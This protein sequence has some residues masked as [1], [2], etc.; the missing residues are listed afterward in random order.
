MIGFN[1]GEIIKYILILFRC[2]GFI[3]LTPIFG[4]REIPNHARIGLACFLAMIV[5]PLIPDFDANMDVLTLA[6][7]I[8][9][10]TFVGLSMGYITL[11]MFSSLYVAGQIIDMQ[12]GFGI[13][14]VIDPQSNSQVP[15]IGNFYYI[16]TLLTF[17]TVNGHHVLI[18]AMIKSFEIVPLSNA[19]F[20]RSFLA[21][22]IQ[23]FR[24]MFAIGFKVSLPVI[25][26]I[27][28][29]DFALGIMARAVP[30][31]N[32][33]IVGLPIKIFI[34]ILG[35]IIIFPMY[36]TALDVIFNGTYDNILTLLRGMLKPP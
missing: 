17:L 35:I 30:Q 28:I 9:R 21:A 25:S 34:G 3:M 15:L 11:M 26:I 19:V 8:L 10:E 7:S 22:I 1:Y 36:L 12:M 29:T 33:F 5:Y 18:S 32:V 4:R 20:G 14:N 27:F 23:S 16:L 2:S 13:V 31:M 24:E 6:T